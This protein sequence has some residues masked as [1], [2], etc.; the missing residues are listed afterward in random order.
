MFLIWVWFSLLI[1]FFCWVLFMYYLRN[2]CLS[3]GPEDNFLLQ[4]GGFLFYPSHLDQC[5]IWTWWCEVGVR[6]VFSIW[7]SSCSAPSSPHGTAAAPLSSVTCGW[8]TLLSLVCRS[9]SCTGAAL[10]CWLWLSEESGQAVQ[11]LQHYSSSGWS[12][13]VLALCISN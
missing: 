2:F 5:S 6:L 8:G 11:V 1:F 4:C 12:F 3:H 7:L 13:P 9:L 10:F